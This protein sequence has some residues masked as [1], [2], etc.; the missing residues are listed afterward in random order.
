MRNRH[1]R[2]T[3]NAH[4]AGEISVGFIGPPVSSNGH[5]AIT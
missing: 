5:C 1:A 2:S 4:S 3:R